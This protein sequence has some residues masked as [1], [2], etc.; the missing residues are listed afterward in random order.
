[1]LRQAKNLAPPSYPSPLLKR[2]MFVF[3]LEVINNSQSQAADKFV[4]S[5][6]P[7]QHRV[8]PPAP[9]SSPPVLTSASADVGP[10]APT[11]GTEVLLVETPLG[12][13]DTPVTPMVV[14][15]APPPSALSVSFFKAKVLAC[16]LLTTGE[17]PSLQHAHQ[18]VLQFNSLE[19]AKI[20][21]G[22]II[23][24]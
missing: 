6:A 2:V 9:S 16:S 22:N 19:T 8:L 14:D 23:W 17:V 4:K 11:Q 13:T 12:D 3:L 1:L 5:S 24:K 20:V 18:V 15:Q 21:I 10:K 7:H